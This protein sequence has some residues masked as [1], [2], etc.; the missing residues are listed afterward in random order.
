[1]AKK[2]KKKTSNK[3]A[4][5]NNKKQEIKVTQTQVEIKHPREVKKEEQD[6]LFYEPKEKELGKL[7]FNIVFW[8]FIC[9]LFFIWIFDFVK[10]KNDEKPFFCIRSTTHE[11]EDGEVQECL[12]LGYKIYT[13]ERESIKG[14]DYGPFFMKM[15]K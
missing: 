3:N 7:I 9:S 8:V 12:G 15:E 6:E 5:T 2:S 1:M 13:Y 11:F 14:V 10:V 4:S